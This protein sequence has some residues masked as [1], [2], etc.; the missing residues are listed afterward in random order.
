MK[1]KQPFNPVA[2]MMAIENALQDRKRI[3]PVLEQLQAEMET[4]DEAKE[5]IEAELAKAKP[6]A[7]EE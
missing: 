7:K 1:K 4:P 2:A 6:P 3:G 5:R